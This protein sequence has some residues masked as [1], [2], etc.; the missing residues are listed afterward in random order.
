MA[1]RDVA[2]PKPVSVYIH[3]PFCRHRCGYCNFSVIANRDDLIARFLDAIDTELATLDRP[4]VQTIFIGGGTPTHLPTGDLSRLLSMVCERFV[5]GDG[6]EVSVECNPED[7]NAEKLQC[8]VDHGVNRISLGVQSFSPEKL[9]IL[10]RGHTPA[11]ACA[12]I[13]LAASAIANVSLDLIF[14]VPGETV[15][16]WQADLE[17]AFSLPIT[18]LSTYALTIEKGT[19]F[20]TRRNSGSF[21][22]P[23]ESCEVEMYE[24]V[25]RMSADAGLPQ[26]E[27]S[28]FSRPGLTCRHNLEYWKGRG[29]Y[30]A[31]PGAARFV[32]G[33]REVNHRSTTTYLRLIESGNSPI[34]E[35]E[36][37]TM[38]T[39]ARERAAFGIRVMAGIDIDAISHETGI[40]LRREC[41]DA[42][43]CSIDEGLIEVSDGR[44]RL[45]D[46]GVLFADTV[47]SRFLD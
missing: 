37:I 1:V 42:I 4:T 24:L 45:T 10:E 27:V 34:A 30:A 5:V 2:W 23:D 17:T 41:S 20:W 26:Y 9:R 33:R 47:A 16:Q 6:A 3:V 32:D 39:C 40:D 22:S 38:A 12:A 36:T 13:E 14:A 11:G 35:S 43:E 46:R 31:G 29:W 25:R 15:A 28:N 21:S 18:H 44:L 7:V 19:S 8:L